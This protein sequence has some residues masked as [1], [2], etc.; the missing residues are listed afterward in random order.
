MFSVFWGVVEHAEKVFYDRQ[1]LKMGFAPRQ[2][3]NKCGVLGVVSGLLW[4]SFG[5]ILREKGAPLPI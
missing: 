2:V 4:G 1:V 3:I 5:F